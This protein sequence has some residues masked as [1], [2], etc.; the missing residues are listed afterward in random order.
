MNYL[1][2]LLLSG[3]DPHVVMGNMVGDFVKGRVSKE[4]YPTWPDH[5]LLG[6]HLHRFI[7]S[8]TDAHPQV[9][10]AKREVAKKFGRISGI[11]IDVYFDYFLAKHFDKF[12]SQPL[13]DYSQ[14]MYRLFRSQ[15]D[16]VPI[17]M[18]SMVDYMIRQD[19]LMSYASFEG[20]DLTFHRMSRRLPYLAPIREAGLELR[21]QEDFYEKIF[22][23]FYPELES[24]CDNFIRQWML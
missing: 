9:R 6:L 13:S 18:E 2:H 20:I 3:S 14:S 1:A 19:W 12:S 10:V 5:Y 21:E 17:Q 4:K 15:H 24:M 7:D 11:I 16:L 23:D 22:L 8:Y